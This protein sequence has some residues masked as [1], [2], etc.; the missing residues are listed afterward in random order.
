M[1][2]RFLERTVIALL[3]KV[4]SVVVVVLLPGLDLL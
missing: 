3:Q 4:V 1:D 2:V